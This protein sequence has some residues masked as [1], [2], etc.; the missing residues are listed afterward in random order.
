PGGNPRYPIATDSAHG[1]HVDLVAPGA[2][3]AAPSPDSAASADRLV[4][5]SGTSFACA[6]VAATAALLLSNYPTL[7]KFPLKTANKVREIITASAAAPYRQDPMAY[8]AGLLRVDE[9]LGKAGETINEE[10]A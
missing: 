4:R 5:V 8:G 6:H 7:G 1:P 10:G 9:A 2:D 3:V